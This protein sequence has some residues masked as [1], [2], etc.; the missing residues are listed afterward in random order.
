MSSQ[1]Q[2]AANQANAQKSSG[3][4]TA[5]GK[6]AV[7]KNALKTGLTG[8]TV[9]LPTD[10]AELYAKHITSFKS[11]YAPVGDEET[12]LVQSIADTSWRIARIPSLETGIYAVGRAKMADLHANIEDKQQRAMMI[13]A[14]VALA[15]ERQIRNLQIQEGRLRRF[16]EKDIAT[17]T[18]LQQ[19]RKSE[20]RN[21][22]DRAA[23][24]YLKAFRDNRHFDPASNG[25]EFSI[26]EIHTHAR[27][28]YPN[29]HLPEMPFQYEEEQAAA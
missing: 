20:R 18:A 26:E 13:E 7:S 22:F 1:A 17:L 27:L 24:A 3:P 16:L 14:E 19:A 12:E 4:V 6:A 29:D 2:I 15:Y 11:R 25:F 10:D 8:R 5:E 23:L 21:Q 28:R 9:L